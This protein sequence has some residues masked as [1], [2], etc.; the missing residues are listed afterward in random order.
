VGTGEGELGKG[1]GE[2]GKVKGG[3]AAA[4]LYFT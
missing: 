3:G 2:R 4:L 1:K